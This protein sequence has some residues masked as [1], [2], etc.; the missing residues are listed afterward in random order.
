MILQGVG[1]QTSHLAPSDSHLTQ[2]PDILLS[3]RSEFLHLSF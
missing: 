1:D 3:L 2:R